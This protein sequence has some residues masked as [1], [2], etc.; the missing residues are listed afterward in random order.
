M[1]LEQEIKGLIRADAGHIA[2]PLF[3]PYVNPRRLGMKIVS[4]QELQDIGSLRA[5]IAL[6]LVFFG[7]AVSGLIASAAALTTTNIAS[8][9]TW[10]GWV[11]ALIVSL[12]G[13]LG[14][15]VLSYLSWQKGK[16]RIALIER[17]STTREIELLGR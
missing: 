12:A 7:I 4:N 14:F 15:G 10:A 9:F 2:E 16:N 5:D 8:P 1:R 11:A 13:T 6:Y 17:E 3:V